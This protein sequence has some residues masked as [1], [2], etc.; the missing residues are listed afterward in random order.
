M[1]RFKREIKVMA[2]VGGIL[3]SHYLF[4]YLI[5]ARTACFFKNT[6]GMPC[7]GCGMTR[8]LTYLLQGDIV[9][10]LYY[11]PL[12][13][14]VIP[15][16]FVMVFKSRWEWAEKMFRSNLFWTIVVVVFVGQYIYRM[17]LYFPH[18]EPLDFYPDGFFPRVYRFFQGS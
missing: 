2:L 15:T 13:F 5:G 11:N 6:F 9:K 14:I 1:Q 18:T 8:A 7:P 10:S 4:A 12:I 3:L 16:F 17:F